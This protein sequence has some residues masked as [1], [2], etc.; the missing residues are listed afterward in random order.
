MLSLWTDGLWKRPE[1]PAENPAGECVA[2]ESEA[3]GTDAAG[4]AYNSGG[5]LHILKRPGPARKLR[6]TLPGDARVIMGYTRMA[7]QGDA[8][9]NRNNHPFSGK[10]GKTRF[11][12]AHNGVLYNHR[13]L[14]YQHGLPETPIETDSYVA[15]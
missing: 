1:P 10:A 12:L 15:V 13:L 11:A 9:H 4:I 14:Q 3:R 7:T 2:R 8:L 6:F 5:K